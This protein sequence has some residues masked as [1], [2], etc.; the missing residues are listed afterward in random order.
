MSKRFVKLAI[1]RA[2]IYVTEQLCSCVCVCVDNYQ[3]SNRERSNSRCTHRRGFI[4]WI[5]MASYI[6]NFTDIQAKM[7]G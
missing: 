4:I 1:A 5:Q 7:V 6:A 2:I 3:G